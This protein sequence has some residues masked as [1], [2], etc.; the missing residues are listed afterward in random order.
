MAVRDLVFWP[1][2]QL[3][4]KSVEVAPEEFSTDALK[5]LANDL[6]DTVAEY[7]G[8]GLSA[9]QLGVFKRVVLIPGANN[10]PLVLINPV[11]IEKSAEVEDQTEGCLSLPGVQLSTKRSKTVKLRAQSLDG[12]AVETQVDGISAVVVQHEIDHLDGK[13]IADDC[14]P[15]RRGLIKAKVEK[16]KRN[17]RK[18]NQRK[19]EAYNASAKEYR[20][21]P[22]GT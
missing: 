20:M 2:A 8:A 10:E 7:R 12:V 22:K 4:M 5:A 21:P 16:N 1:S 19:A 18:H 11:L 9:P 3:T 14:G 17:L 6:I 15:V 13:T